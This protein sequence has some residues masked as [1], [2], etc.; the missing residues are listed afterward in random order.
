MEQGTIT[1]IAINTS[2]NGIETSKYRQDL[3]IVRFIN[4]SK[5]KNTKDSLSTIR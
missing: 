4:H 5:T 2:I 3:M 1:R